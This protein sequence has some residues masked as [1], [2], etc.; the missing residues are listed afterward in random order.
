MLSTNFLPGDILLF[1]DHTS[2]RARYIADATKGPFHHAGLV[3]K[4]F[5]DDTWEVLHTGPEGSFMNGF[6]SPGSDESIYVVR[7]NCTI[8]AEQL[9]QAAEESLNL[10]YEKFKLPFIG[11]AAWDRRCLSDSNLVFRLF[12]KTL[13][14]AI[15]KAVNRIGSDKSC[16][17]LT[18]SILERVISRPLFPDVT[19]SS[20]KFSPNCIYEE[21]IKRKADFSIFCVKPVSRRQMQRTKCH[22]I[23]AGLLLPFYMKD[24]AS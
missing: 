23:I 14:K 7:P 10:T 16:S 24:S 13:S 3:I 19:V 6:P 22:F 20:D 11:L 2:R 9:R 8:D 12:T 5:D 21:A 17:G 15:V 4:A 18:L 1:S